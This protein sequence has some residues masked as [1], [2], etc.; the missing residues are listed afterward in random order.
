MKFIC[1]DVASGFSPAMALGALLDM[2]KEEG[3]ANGLLRPFASSVY[4]EKVQRGG[5][6]ALLAHIDIS[7]ITESAFENCADDAFL[8]FASELK[9]LS[10]KSDIREI[11]EAL[12]VLEL[13]KSFGIDS[14]CYDCKFTQT[15]FED[16]TESVNPNCVSAPGYALLKLLKASAGFPKSGDITLVGYGAESI[17]K[18]PDGIL[19]AMLY[20]ENRDGIFFAENIF[21]TLFTEEISIL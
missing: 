6:E 14:V 5:F 15:T 13:I 12:C 18:N 9:K 1:F 16:A 21:E 19:R 2:F 7:D 17:A 10:P 11:L 4:T 8:N 3:Y 20:E